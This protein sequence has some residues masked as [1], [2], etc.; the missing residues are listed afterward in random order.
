V[1]EEEPGEE[2]PVRRFTAEEA[3]ALLP[4]VTPLVEALRRAHAVME[5]RQD[6]V[7]ESIPTNG[8]GVIHREFVDA[9][10]EAG[11][12]IESLESLGLVVRDPSS[13]LVD[14]P[15][16]IGG[17]EVFLCWRVGEASV[18][19]WHPPETGFAGRQPI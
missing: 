17:E 11:R 3:N 9:S 13:G 14:F 8:G 4:A 6:D 5:E 10:T 15:A 2:R 7:M 18:A 12:A 16:I 1:S 19:W